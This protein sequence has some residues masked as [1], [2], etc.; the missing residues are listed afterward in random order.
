MAYVSLYRK[1]RP[2]TFSEILGQ[3][4]I[5]TTLA[6]AITEDRVA[7]AYLFT[8]PRGTGKTSTARIL[9]KALNC[10]RG[11]TPEPCGKC[12][13]C[14]A[15]AAG[16]SM[17]VFEMDAA[18]HSGVDETREILSGVPLATAGGRRKV[19]VIDEVH[20]LTTQSFNALLKTLEEPPD[21]VI[22][23]LATTE[24]HKV[25]PT[26]VS[27]TQRFDFRRMPLSSLTQLLSEVAKQEGID[28]DPDAIE[29]VARHA[30]G[31]GRD[32]LSAL[33]Q[34]R[35]LEGSISV[36][37]ADRLLGERGE[38]AFFQLFDA[39]SNGDLG[40]IFTTLDS[41]ITQGADVRQLSL[42]A[43]DH[44]RS[45][46]LLKT[47]PQAQDLLDV[48]E[49][50]RPRLADQAGRFRIGELLRVLDLVGK[51]IT[52]MRNA[53]NHRLFLE[54]A[55]ARATSPETDPSA[56]GLLGRIERLERR[57][58]LES[59]ASSGTS[60]ASSETSPAPQQDAPSPR[61]D[62]PAASEGQGR[63]ERQAGAPE[64]PV[65]ASGPDHLTLGHIKDAWPSAMKQVSE[66]SKRVA[67]FLK[68]SLP[69]SFE[70]D[71]LVVEVQSSF[72]VSQMTE[73]KNS[74]A[75]VESIYDALG[76]RPAVR[77]TERGESPVEPTE[78]AS[79]R[80]SSSSQASQS[81]GTASY[82]EAADAVDIEHDPIEMLKKGFDAEVVREHEES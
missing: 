61:R 29:V 27:R 26:I 58:G 8:G 73:P 65:A 19:Y 49:E 37:D 14:V 82:A 11:P 60:P 69:V 62:A 67:A 28:I 17:D 53:P 21:H 35:T 36:A 57:I 56:E 42:G 55:L 20:M 59:T 75:L 66:R 47:A 77:F 50:D 25:L 81:K 76:I 74:E 32:A 72:H 34:L 71:D 48:H 33:D 22:F 38:D 68:P 18:S 63:P 16:S 5:S 4:H 3:E 70:G 1:Y 78:T 80:G 15:I 54:V 12:S 39:I 43:L 40:S 64:P 7:H 51:A 24:A 79:G 9:A 2:Q 6:N 30:D 44:A 23:V 45:L 10:E 13:S 52:E 41:M 31:G 46:M